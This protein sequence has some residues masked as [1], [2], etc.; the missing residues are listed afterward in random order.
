MT[1]AQL[2]RDIEY[3]AGELRHRGAHT[4]KEQ[5][6]AEYIR[7]RFAD[8]GADAWVDPFFCHGSGPALLA[9]HY[10]EFVV[11]ALFGYWWPWLFCGYGVSV[12]AV[13]MAELR[14]YRL[15]SRWMPQFETQN[16]L[17]RFPGAYA[18]QCVIVTA[19]YDSAKDHILGQPG[20]Q[21]WVWLG[22]CAVMLCMVVVLASCAA[23][24]M[25]LSRE[26][27]TIVLVPRI[28]AAL[29]LAVTCGA[30]LLSEAEAPDTPGAI[31]NASG[32]AV[33]LGLAER[34]QES[35]IDGVDVW[36]VATGADEVWM[37]GMRRLLV[38]AK[39]GKHDTRIINI[40]DVGVGKVRYVTKER[41]VGTVRSTKSLVN[42]AR[43]TAEAGEFEDIEPCV[44]EGMPSSAYQ[45]LA[46]GY[47]AMTVTAVETRPGR[48]VPFGEEDTP[49]FIN[50]ETL[51]TTGA[52][53]EALLRRMAKGE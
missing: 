13:Y 7:A 40:Q 31:H 38:S 45:A 27:E 35:P 34:L 33:L 15:S 32:V 30:L 46:R 17:G 24:G 22:H 19:H 4:E 16:V 2:R 37:N 51:T 8:C 41:V 9:L 42:L 6:A 44:R 29:F 28:L 3:L 12:F 49:G 43:E 25:G 14:G 20:A 21:R 5:A 18:T 52:Y 36:L 53:V 39:P 11:V 26:G 1:R 47:R 23:Q 50:Y 10:V 48:A